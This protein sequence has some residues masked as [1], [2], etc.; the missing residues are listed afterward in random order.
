MTLT[1]FTPPAAATPALPTEL[2]PV[3]IRAA[4]GEA[5]FAAVA[6]LRARTYGRHV[7]SMKAALQQPDALDRHASATVLM[8]HAKD[9]GRLV[10]TM[11][12]QHNTHGPLVIEASTP[13]PA[14]LQALHL[15]EAARLCIEQGAPAVVR[16][17]L[18]KALFLHCAQCRVDAIVAVARR[19]LDRI[20]ERLQFRN[21]LGAGVEVP[22]KHIGNLPH[23]LLY[24][25]VAELVHGGLGAEHPMH[26]FVVRTHHPDIGLPGAP[27]PSD[28]AAE[29][30]RAA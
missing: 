22:M 8:A 3:R 2:L 1:F 21:A 20:Y 4:R 28:D 26:G 19:P 27:L 16:H 29:R 10:G 18:F 24:L 5:D 11:R 9:D 17:A 14:A 23:Q 30:R 13:L 6:A 25:S 7:P 12:M 15:V